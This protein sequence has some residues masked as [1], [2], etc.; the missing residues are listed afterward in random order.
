MN[1]SLS[2]IRTALEVLAST[3]SAYKGTERSASQTFLNHLIAA[4]S[5]EVDAM[6]AGARFEEFGVRDEGSGFMDLYWQ[7]V[8]I[9]EMKAPSQS[10]RLDQHRAQ[11]LDYW[12]N[13]A[14]N[15]KGIAAPPYLIL[16]SIRAFEIWE[17]G[18]FP[19]APVDTFSIEDLPARAEALLFLAGRQPIFGGPGAKV[20]A[21]AAKHMVDLYFGL[22]ERKAVTPAELRRFIVQTVWTLFAEDVGILESRPL[23]TLVRALLADTTRSTAVELADLYRRFDIQDSERR[24][25]GRSNSVPYVNGEL[26]AT[27]VEVHLNKSELEDLLEASRFDWQFVNPTVFGSLLEGCLGHDHRWELGAHYTNEQDIMLIIEPV[28]IRPWVKRIESTKNFKEAT[29]LHT[30]LCKFKVID[31]AM[32]CGNFLSVAY[33][34][35]RILELRLHDRISQHAIQDGHQAPLEMQYYPINNVQGIEIEPFAVDI[36]KTTLWMT[37]ALESRRHGIAEPV[38]PLP[39]LTSLTCA[40]SLKTDWPE[41][42]VV[43][44]NPPFHGDRNMRSVLGDEYIDWLKSEFGVGVKDHCVYFF[45]KTHK[46]LKPGQRAGL[47][48]TKTISQTK[49]RDASLVW[50]TATNGVITDAISTKDWSGEAAVDVSIV[51]WTKTPPAPETCILDGRKVTGITPSLTEGLVHRGAIKLKGNLRICFTG[52]YTR[53]MGFVITPDEAKSLIEQGGE[54]YLEVVA[55]FSSG[56]DTVTTL[57]QRPSRWVIDFADKAL[58]DVTERFPIALQI[59]RERVLPERIG[60]PELM[61][62]WWQFWMT[63]KGLRETTRTLPRFAIASRHCKRLILVWAEPNWRPSDGCNVFTFTDDFNFGICS[64][65]IHEIWARATSSTLEDRLR[66]NPSTAFETFPFPS[67]SDSQRERVST[68]AS[69]MVRLRTEASRNQRLGL[70]KVY[71]LMDEGGFT[72]LKAA[73]HELDLAVIDAYGWDKLLLGN[74]EVLLSKLFDLNES[75]AKDPNY[76]PFGKSDN[77]SLFTSEQDEDDE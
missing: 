63:R 54:H 12:R 15:E 17:P 71:N 75:C 31:P 34:E 45:L 38:L 25:R 42:D 1:R 20:T 40:D 4:Y 51:C 3:W 65:T 68:A 58:E 41:T 74:R 26:F 55:P 76:D 52:Y 13:S 24:N 37:H 44:G 14:N 61:K 59:L 23:E 47:V 72:E 27:A 6:S 32:G 36:A 21:Q 56:D 11:A 19:T 18:R 10:R 30:E 22:L 28:I 33:R 46:N 73:H 77:E 66:Y 69:Q 5:G 16:C 48:A 7:G 49:N 35:L 39:A 70:T 67:A 64:S 60:K 57:D 2:D 29:R 50:I 43:I 62:R 8:V 9:I 53:G